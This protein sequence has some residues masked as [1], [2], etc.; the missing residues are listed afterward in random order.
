MKYGLQ[1]YT[2]RDLTENQMG[3][4][5]REVAGMGYEGIELAG[6]G[7][8]TI[9]EL[10]EE[11]KETGLS[12][13]SAHVGYQE[14][15]NPDKWIQTAKRIGTSR[16]TIPW[17]D[18]KM[19]TEDEIGETAGMLNDITD[20][21][22]SEG[23]ELSYHNHDYEFVD[24]RYDR[25]M[26][27][28]P[29]LKFE[30]DTYWVKFAGYNPIELMKKY[31]D[32]I[33]LVHLKDMLDKEKVVHEDPNPVLMTGVMDTKGIIN[34]AKKMGIPWGIVEMDKTV[35]DSL[36]AVRESLQNILEIQ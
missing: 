15:I 11:V 20:R 1:M 25:L 36:K 22:E 8:L 5:L 35:G 6:F 33:V 31:S 32:R 7:N 18:H 34:Q 29:K 28:C 10:A 16:I 9:D 3:N 12:V 19:L 2:L 30:L 23:I 26:Q 21:L 14:L 24:G 4:T 27:K 17:M 13:I